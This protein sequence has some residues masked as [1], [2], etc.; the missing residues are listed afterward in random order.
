M[1]ISAPFLKEID[2][3]NITMLT[4]LHSPNFA[5]GNEMLNKAGSIL[6]RTMHTSMDSIADLHKTE[7]LPAAIGG[8]VGKYG[9]YV[10]KLP[11]FKAHYHFF[12]LYYCI[13]YIY[14]QIVRL[15]LVK[16]YY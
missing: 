14:R 13:L 2:Y 4:S 3:K 8:C 10:W 6:S 5:E 7:R 16:S 9:F 11:S 1:V 12:S 15:G